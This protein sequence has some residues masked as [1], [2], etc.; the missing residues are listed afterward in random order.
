MIITINRHIYILNVLHLIIFFYNSIFEELFLDFLRIL[1]SFNIFK[2]KYYFKNGEI[3]LSL[4][5]FSVLFV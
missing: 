4:F 3:T 5:T 2:E 1:C